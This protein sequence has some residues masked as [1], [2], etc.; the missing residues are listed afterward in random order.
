MA[1]KY[2]FQ[3]LKNGLTLVSVPTQAESI[4]VLAL[5]H[6]GSRDETDTQHG[7]AHFLEHFV[8][9]G[10]KQFPKINDTTKIIDEVGGEQNA[11]TNNDFTGFWAKVSSDQWERA[12]RVVGQLVSEPIFPESELEKEK[13]AIIEEINMYEDSHP[14][15]AWTVFEKMLFGESG[16]GR[17][18]L[19]TQKSIKAMSV[20]DLKSFRSR[21]YDPRNVVVV[22]VGSLPKGVDLAKEVENN[23]SSLSVLS[24]LT[25]RVGYD[26]DFTQ[27]D[28]RVVITKKPTEQAHLVLGVKGISANDKRLYTLAVLDKILGGNMSSRLWNEVREKRGLA[29]YVRSLYDTH[30][31]QGSVVVRAG[32]RLKDLA[33]AVK[34][35]VGELSGIA[36]SKVSD[37]ELLRGKEGVKGSLKLEMEDTQSIAELVSEDWALMNGKVRTLEEIVAQV[38]QVSAEDIQKLARELFVNKNLN[39]SV[40]GPF[41]EKI[42][43]DLNKIL[44]G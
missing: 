5:V 19:G 13:G 28:P 16:L 11:F 42:E 21:W 35:T 4:S 15:K 20:D 17:P 39:L 12:I 22:V 24:T 2:N 33:E 44:E 23:F 36:S 37:E 7:A 26:E 9:K 10:T 3:T 29:Y 25:K 41:D 18:I 27:D 31:D 34:V 40:V 1:L 32:V 30:S 38:D 14:N 8:F 6:A 43:A